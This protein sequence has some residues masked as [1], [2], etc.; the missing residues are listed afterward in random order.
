MHEGHRERLRE[1]LE[2]HGEAL[3]DIQIL[4]MAL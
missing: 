2:S 1:K 3:T 4:E